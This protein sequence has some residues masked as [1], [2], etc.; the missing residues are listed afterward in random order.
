ML[1]EA[2]EGM[3]QMTSASRHGAVGR[4]GSQSVPQE[5]RDGVVV[6]VV[7]VVVA[8]VVDEDVGCCLA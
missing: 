3:A 2:P 4:L 7:E 5:M 1:L 6:V 8:D